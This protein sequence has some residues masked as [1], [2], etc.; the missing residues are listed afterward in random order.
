M[1]IGLFGGTFDP[2]T[3]AHVAL[4]RCARD[5]LALDELRIVPA[6]RPWQKEAARAITPAAD[7]LAMLAL[8]FA[9]EPRCSVDRL[10]IDR[11]GPSYTID[12]VR[13]LRA[14]HPDATLYLVIGADACAGL[15]TW[16]EWPALLEQVTLAVAPRPGTPLAAAPA[17]AAAARVVELPLL[18]TDLSSTVARARAAAGQDLTG[19]V[20]PEVARYIE[21]QGVYRPRQA[22]S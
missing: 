12:T 5:A 11:D 20:P 4:A 9:G 8:A 16:R 14:A 7:R 19:L 18:A 6:G 3:L 21:T 10:E 2:P 13:A 15:S 1:R 22:R 17:V